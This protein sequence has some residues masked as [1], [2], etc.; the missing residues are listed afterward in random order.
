MR[1]VLACGLAL[2]ALAL[3]FLAMGDLPRATL[4]L[5]LAV[6]AVAAAPFIPFLSE[7]DHADADD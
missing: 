2:G 3:A 1:A 6:A 7:T 4:A 5:I